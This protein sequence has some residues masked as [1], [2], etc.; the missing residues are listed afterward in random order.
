M[1]FTERHIMEN[2]SHVFKIELITNAKVTRLSRKLAH[3]I[4]DSGFN[5]DIVIS[6]AR[7]GYIPARLI[8]DYLYL[9]N[10]T[11]IR[12]KHYTGSDKAEAAQLIDPLSI[13]I[14]GMK[15]LL[16]DDIDD[17]GD[18]LQVALNYLASFNPVEIKIAVLHHK[19]IS[20]LV[21]DYYA[22]KIIHW[23]WIIY[24]WAVT[25][26][27]FEFIKK[28]QPKPSTIEKAIECL[29]QDYKIKVSKQVMHDVFRLL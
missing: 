10:L 27:V 18:T 12:I 13:N 29:E 25:E 20:S 3:K 6:I 26:D 22:K 8:C 28:I 15:V 2:S 5:P 19:V 14:K 11:S 24:P 23:R 4:Q 7:G 1:F 9:Y 17:T 21:P 16:V